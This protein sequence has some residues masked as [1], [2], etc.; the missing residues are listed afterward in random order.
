MNT[1]DSLCA[2]HSTAGPIMIDSDKSVWNNIQMIM[3]VKGMNWANHW[4]G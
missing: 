1:F 4:N 3:L 2:V